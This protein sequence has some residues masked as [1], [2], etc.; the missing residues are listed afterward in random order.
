[1]GKMK[2]RE[3]VPNGPTLALK[4][5]ITNSNKYDVKIT[6]LA[7]TKIDVTATLPGGNGCTGAGDGSA[8]LTSS[9]TTGIVLE[10]GSFEM[11]LAEP[12][13]VPKESS[14]TVSI[15]AAVKM[16]NESVNDC[17]G[18]TFQLGFKVTGESAA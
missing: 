2:K 1:M 17:Q 15:P 3:L 6:K 14:P 8:T 13:T 4:L 18:D 16:T 7:L 5:K 10:S 11:T 9:G 12:I